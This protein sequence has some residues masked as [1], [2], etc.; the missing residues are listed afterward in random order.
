MTISRFF[1]LGVCAYSIE[2]SLDVFH[3]YFAFTVIPWRPFWNENLFNINLGN[4]L[5]IYLRLISTILIVKLV[6]DA[7]NGEEFDL[8]IK[9]RL[10]NMSYM[11]FAYLESQ[12][13]FYERT[14]GVRY[15][16]KNSSP[17]MT[18]DRL[19]RKYWER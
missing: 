7:D 9:H 13:Y 3:S 6:Y 2:K 15:S 16:A 11:Q 18:F 8:D 14:K 17:K 1:A 10:F 12:T 5:L 19:W 4:V